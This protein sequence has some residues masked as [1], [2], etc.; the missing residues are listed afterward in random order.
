M[1]TTARLART[2]P[3]TAALALAIGAFAGSGGAL[4]SGQEA[5]T[6]S[7]VETVVQAEVAVRGEVTAIDREARLVTLETGT[8]S[9]ILPVDPRVADFEHLR[10]GDVIDVRYH[11]SVLFDIQ[12]AGSA[13]PGAWIGE[14]GRTADRDQGVPARIGEQE[15]TVLAEV[16]E[17]DAEHGNFTVKGPNGSVRTLQAEKPEHRAEVG[18]IRVG[19]LLR[20]RFREGLAVSLAKVE[21]H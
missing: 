19:D 10:V 5:G 17:V 7:R 1:T 15:V 4:A 13:E 21:L 12:P 14:E 11:R 20:V 9:R 3:A 18:R 16:V 6:G 8:G 2:I